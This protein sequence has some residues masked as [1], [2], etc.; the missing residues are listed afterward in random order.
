MGM[1][2]FFSVPLIK[3]STGKDA[4]SKCEL[5]I[6]ISQSKL[7]GD[8]I[9]HLLSCPKALYTAHNS[10]YVF[11]S[12]LTIIKSCFPKI[13]EPCI[14]YNGD[15]MCLSHCWKYTFILFYLTGTMLS[16]KSLIQYSS[17][18]TYSSEIIGICKIV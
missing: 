18:P 8:Y 17:H 12:I 13:Y 2:H 1:Y 5:C 4:C 9:Y 16:L 11:C 15:E 3:V 14:F 10:I 6:S 7:K